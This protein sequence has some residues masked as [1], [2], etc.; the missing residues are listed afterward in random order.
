MGHTCSQFERFVSR[1]NLGCRNK[2]F[3]LY[4]I[5]S[6][7]LKGRVYEVSL[8]DLQNE[9]DAERSFKKFKLVRKY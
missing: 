8:A 1:I 3:V 6:D 9:Q 2:W 4:R 5:A 7:G